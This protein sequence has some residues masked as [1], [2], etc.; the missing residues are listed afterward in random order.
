MPRAASGLGLRL[1]ER[2]FRRVVAPRR[3]AIRTP[4]LYEL[5]AALQRGGA[6]DGKVSFRDPARRV[7]RRQAN[8]APE[9]ERIDL[10]V[11]CK[12]K[13]RTSCET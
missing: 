9:L 4:L 13:S 7:S 8:L 11:A 12:E 3:R 6:R 2:P 5:G 10:C 1:H